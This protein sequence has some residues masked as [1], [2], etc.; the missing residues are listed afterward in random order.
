ML[1]AAKQQVSLIGT[2]AY[3]V[4]K[5]R[6]PASPYHPGALDLQKLFARMVEKR[7]DTVV[8]EVSSHALALDRTAGSGSTSRCLQI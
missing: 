7:L 6:S 1:E 8:M 5:S 3:L 2:V 4:G